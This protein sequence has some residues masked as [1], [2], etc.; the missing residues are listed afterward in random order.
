MNGNDNGTGRANSPFQ[1]FAPLGYGSKIKTGQKIGLA[2]NSHWRAPLPT[3]ATIGAYRQ[4][5]L[6]IT[7]TGKPNVIAAYA[8]AQG[9][10]SLPILDGS[11]VI[12]NGVFASAGTSYP[13]A[14][15]TPTEYFYGGADGYEIFVWETG[16]SNDNTMGQ[17]L[18]RQFS[19]S[20]VS[21]NSCSYY[22]PGLAWGGTLPSS[23][24][25]YVHACDGSNPTTNGYT[26]EVSEQIPLTMASSGSTISNIELRKTG[27]NT[28]VLNL[29][30]DCGSYTVIGVVARDGGKHNALMPSGSTVTNSEFIDGYYNAAGIGDSFLVFHDHSTSACG[31][32][33]IEVENSVF[34]QDQVIVGAG[35]SGNEGVI[36]HTDDGSL[37][38]DVSLG[39]VWFIAKNGATLNGFGF[40]NVSGVAGNYLYGSQLLSGVAVNQSMTLTNSQFV[41]STS[42]NNQIL[43]QTSRVTLKATKLKLCGSNDAAGLLRVNAAKDLKIDLTQSQLYVNSPNTN[44]SSAIYNLSDDQAFNLKTVDVGSSVANWTPLEDFGTGNRFS[45]NNN[46]YESAGSPGWY[47]N[48][49]H[50]SSLAAWQSAVSPSDAASTEAGGTAIAACSLPPIPT[51]N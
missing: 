14:F 1:T 21:S 34:Q 43:F 22:I 15:V 31:A 25:I 12:P 36:S 38:G 16:A 26:Y 46:I 35:S 13:G 49:K 10:K 9:C 2:C 11:A 19:E 18:S 4:S 8:P 33:P 3:A 17:F 27:S 20:A 42:G 30:N 5:V 32:L 45:G 28:G 40:A 48:G 50:Y 51:V 39:H 23:A 41:S 44:N 7:G 24:P 6:S 29:N 47:F 37:M